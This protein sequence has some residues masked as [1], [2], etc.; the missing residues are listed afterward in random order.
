MAKHTRQ[1]VIDAARSLTPEWGQEYLDDAFAGCPDATEGLILALPDR[2]RAAMVRSLYRARVPPE[3]FRVALEDAWTQTHHYNGVLREARS[4]A[5]FVRWCRYAAFE[6]PDD[7]PDPVT[8]Y[9]G[10]PDVEAWD[11]AHGVSWTLDRER[12]EWF[13]N[14]WE[15]DPVV[16]ACTVPK[17]SLIFY[18]NAREEQEVIPDILPPRGWRRITE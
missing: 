2:D 7:I 11:A 18:S 12:A 13:A 5:Q 6:L 16:V 8:I 3:A 9:R 17:A 14:R 10:I 4:W 1:Q 15:T